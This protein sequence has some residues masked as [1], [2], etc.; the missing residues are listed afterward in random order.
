[1]PDRVK[2]S[3][4]SNIFRQSRASNFSIHSSFRSRIITFNHHAQQRLCSRISHDQS[5]APFNTSF[6][7]RIAACSA[8][9]SSSG[10]LRDTR[11]PFNNCGAGTQS[12]VRSSSDC[13]AST[14]ACATFNV[15]SN[16]SPDRRK[17]E[18]IMCPDGSPPSSR[19]AA[20]HLFE[21]VSIAYCRRAS[22]A[23]P[24]SPSIF[25]SA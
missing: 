1:M 7:S 24:S 21:D 2:R 5:S 9:N 6:A 3:S 4:F 17:S 13:L 22:D 20:L 18:K 16:P 15:V 23:M 8:V 14:I 11:T 12:R 19:A 25:S 10:I